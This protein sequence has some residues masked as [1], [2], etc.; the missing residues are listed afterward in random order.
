[1]F[2][3]GA[4]M[5]LFLYSSSLLYLA[6]YP[7]CFEVEQICLSFLMV[8][9]NEID[10]FVF[11]GF[12]FAAF[13]WPFLRLMFPSDVSLIFLSHTCFSLLSSSFSVSISLFCIPV[14]SF[15]VYAGIVW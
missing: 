10:V 1:M 13:V 7:E 15:L 11:V 3:A 6:L 2:G 12:L 9:F 4:A 8:Y 5:F 14:T